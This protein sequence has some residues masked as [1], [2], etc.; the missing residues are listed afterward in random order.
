[1]AVD[2]RL[3]AQARIIIP[4]AAVV[5]F[6]LGGWTLRNKLAADRQ[7]EWVHA[8]RGDLVTGFEVSGT[9]AAVNSESL[10][11]PQLPDVWN[12]KIAMLAPEGSDVKQG[13]PVVGFDTSELQRRLE[14]KTAVADQARKQI[15]KERA[16]LALQ[17]KSERMRLAETEAR[18]RKTQ[19]KLDTPADIDTINERKKAEIE[20]DIAKRE[21]AVIRARIASLDRA[22]TARIALLETRR[23]NA[24]SIVARTRDAIRQMRVTSPR[25]G[26][27]VYKTNWRGEKKKIG[28]SVWKAERVVEIP[29]LTQMKAEGEVD[30][31]DAG[32]VAVGQRVTLRL[33]AHPDE[34]FQGT[35]TRAGRTV[36]L[37]RGTRDPIKVLRVEI[38]LDRTDPAKMRPGM[39]FQGTVELGRVRNAVLIPREAVHAGAT[40]PFAWRRRAFDVEAVPLR[41]GRQNEKSVEVVRGLEPG[42]RVLVPR[43]AEEDES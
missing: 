43:M 22:A 6:L 31:V 38:A 8:T 35:I 36:Q 41:L 28:D 24:E 20:H 14:E 13:Q 16:D 34:E 25:E 9:L 11:P 37:R 2:R 27:V 12:F 1:M 7:G 33:D 39:R 40:G 42:D 10:G 4:A 5:V 19:L 17:T 30:E 3:R 32:R 18:L 26:T 15:E 29:D 23:D 21:A